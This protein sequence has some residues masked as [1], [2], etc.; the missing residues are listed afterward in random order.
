MGETFYLYANRQDLSRA[1]REGSALWNLGVQDLASVLYLLDDTPVDVSCWGES[2]VRPGVGDVAFC[3][4][5]FATGVTVHLHLSSLDPQTVRRLVL[6]GSR[7]M[8]VFDELAVERA[9]TIHDRAVVPPRSPGYGP[10]LRV[11]GDGSVLSPAIPADDPLQAMCET[12]LAAVRRGRPLESEGSLAVRVVAV[13]EA[14][15]R[16]LDRAGS[17]EVVSAPARR[18]PNVV[19][20]RGN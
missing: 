6:V 16:S 5:R 3:F 14:L 4:L 8:A 9:L 15:Q 10:S 11:E 2:Y 18:L 20:I 12:F 1:R 17:A 19:A 13:L 7:Q